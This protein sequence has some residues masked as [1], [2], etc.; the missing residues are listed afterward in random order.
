MVAHFQAS[1]TH[2][3]TQTRSRQQSQCVQIKI[4]TKHLRKHW[5]FKKKGPNNPAPG[6]L[7][8]AGINNSQT[9]VTWR[10]GPTL[11]IGTNKKKA[12]GWAEILDRSRKERPLLGVFRRVVKFWGKKRRVGRRM[13]F[14]VFHNLSTWL[15]NGWGLVLGKLGRFYIDLIMKI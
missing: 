10:P 8:Q 6:M 9:P 12:A 1:S 11:L 15:W 13:S 3:H 2:T 5:M 14:C 4:P 7:W